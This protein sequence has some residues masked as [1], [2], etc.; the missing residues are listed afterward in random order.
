M[1]TG[2]DGV[3]FYISH[4]E[5]DSEWAAWIAWTLEEAGHSTLL[6]NW[7][8]RPGT[9]I[10]LQIQ[11][12]A[13]RSVR[14]ILVITSAYQLESSF[15]DWSN[16][17]EADRA[18]HLG[19]II[20]VRVENVPLDG[21]I[22]DLISVDLIGVDEDT[23]RRRL[24]EA[25]E[26]V[27]KKPAMQPAF[28]GRW[29]TANAALNV[30][31]SEAAASTKALREEIVDCLDRHNIRQLAREWLL[32]DQLG[33][34][35][36]GASQRSLMASFG[37]APLTDLEFNEGGLYSTYTA[38]VALRAHE[39]NDS[40]FLLTDAA[41]RAL[42]Y[43][44]E[45]QASNGGFGRNVES[46]SGKEILRSIRHT[47]FAISSIMMLEGPRRAVDLG[48][49]FL[50]QN[51]ENAQ[52]LDE[53]SP[54]T[55]PAALLALQAGG[56][57][58]L[59]DAIVESLIQ[60]LVN[61]AV[62]TQRAPLWS[63]YGSY[64]QMLFDTALSTIDLLPNPTPASLAPTVTRAILHIAAHE[65]DGGIPYYSESKI[66]DIGMSSL[67]LSVLIRRTLLDDSLAAQTRDSLERLA[68]S[69][70]TFI[71]QSWSDDRFWA[72]TYT[73][74]IQGILRIG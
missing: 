58:K 17:F 35:G 47:V 4:A 18:G 70:T 69:L 74:T 50:N 12:A 1:E 67:M 52:W 68:H 28:P 42:R 59:D 44:L 57:I 8:F 34:G 65:R 11:R 71:T 63:P 22:S 46:V 49:K 56:G 5:V 41:Q 39:G 36:W 3:D 31:V 2:E 38:L 26:G 10:I 29:R 62:S 21:V 33:S 13:R 73:S 53:A 24:I 7:D 14:T 61:G 20:P 45:R 30:P 23:A 51:I 48:I 55:A 54:S 19:T 66:P 43:F 16:A 25:A 37:R 40:T 15:G 6:R 32:K 60:E 72:Y 27:R 64:P 9:N